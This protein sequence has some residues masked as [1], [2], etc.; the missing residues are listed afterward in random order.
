VIIA[1]YKSTFTIPYHT[2]ILAIKIYEIKYNISINAIY[3]HSN[4]CRSNCVCVIR[5]GTRDDWVTLFDP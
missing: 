2:L 4:N 1:L 5:W 3:T